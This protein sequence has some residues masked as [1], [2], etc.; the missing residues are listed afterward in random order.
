M[1]SDRGRPLNAIRLIS[2]L[3]RVALMITLGLG[4]L[5]WSA[6]LLRWS[7]VLVFLA[8]IGFPA[9]HELFGVIGAIGLLILGG[10]AICTRG[11][12]LLGAGGVIYALMVPAFGMTQTLILTG[13]LHWLIQVAHLL[14]G[15][16]AM[17][18]VMRIE[19]RFQSRDGIATGVC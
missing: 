3:A 13:S 18:L 14:V 10:I 12:R 17:A 16:G 1:F 6:Q 8:R 15:L 4:L 2:L 7:G 19:K 11:R 9:I 5:Y